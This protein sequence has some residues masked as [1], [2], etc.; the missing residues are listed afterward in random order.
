MGE[1]RVSSGPRSDDAMSEKPPA[2]LQRKVQARIKGLT[3]K[4]VGTVIDVLVAQVITDL[5]NGEDVRLPGLGVLRQQHFKAF[6]S[7][8][9]LSGGQVDVPARRGIFFKASGFL[10]GL[11]EEVDAIQPVDTG[12]GNTPPDQGPG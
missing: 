12:P 2:S 11:I 10:E 9:P 7:W 4:Q 1:A 6:K 5:A 3:F 8:S